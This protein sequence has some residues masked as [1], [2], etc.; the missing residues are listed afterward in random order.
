[1]PIAKIKKINFSRRNKKITFDES[2][3]KE[4]LIGTTVPA[5]IEYR[6]KNQT[7]VP[8]GYV[9]KTITENESKKRIGLKAERQSLD[10]KQRKT[11]LGPSFG[12]VTLIG[13]FKQKSEFI[14]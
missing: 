12:N 11:R 7:E 5:K 9:V 1:M 4:N 6:D 8:P 13:N 14:F 2:P 3:K 10:V